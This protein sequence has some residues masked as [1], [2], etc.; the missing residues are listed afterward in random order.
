MPKVLIAPAT[1]AGIDAAFLKTL[2]DAGFELAFPPVVRQLSE[3]ELL[4]QLKGVSAAIAGS[5]PY[6]RRV[7]AA[8]P[9]LRII[10]RSGVGYDAVDVA[11]A[12]DHGVAVT[13]TPG[14]NQDAVAEHTFA[15]ILALAKDLINQ[16]QGVRD[17]SWPRR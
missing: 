4:A 8:H 2:T 10:A 6:T 15:L 7:L 3:E 1:L 14:T 17:A 5:E 12:T 16:H 11:A 13:I 9:Q